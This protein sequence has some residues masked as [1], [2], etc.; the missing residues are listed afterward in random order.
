[1]FRKVSLPEI[2]R[3]EEIVSYMTGRTICESRT[4]P[5][6]LKKSL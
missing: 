5:S 1:M 3:R 4:I 6:S 2:G